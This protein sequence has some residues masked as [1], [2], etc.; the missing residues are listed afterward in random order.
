MRSSKRL[1]ILSQVQ[2]PSRTVLKELPSWIPDFSVASKPFLFGF[3]GQRHFSAAGPNIPQTEPFLIVD[4]A[5]S[6]EGFLVDTV[7]CAAET[8]GCYFVRTAAI[9]SQLPQFYHPRGSY[10]PSSPT[11]IEAY[12]KTLIADTMEDVY[13]A[14]FQFGFGFSAWIAEELL[15]A[16]YISTAMKT[17][18]RVSSAEQEADETKFNTLG[19]LEKGEHEQGKFH[20]PAD[21]CGGDNNTISPA[22]RGRV[23]L[24][25]DSE[26]L[27]SCAKEGPEVVEWPFSRRSRKFA[28]RFKD[29]KRG[30]RM[31]RTADNYLGLGPVSTEEGD[32]IWIL[33]GAPVPFVLRQVNEGRY[34]VI[35]EAYVHGIM[36]GEAVQEGSTSNSICLV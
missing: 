25:P 18:L 14:P 1:N 27:K 13:P 34:R 17:K 35:G 32:Q 8:R 16:S 22:P 5:L 6:M 15:S 11:R 7:L 12:W 36:H 31:F 33:S 24:L 26:F 4:E 9:V 29:V 10:S 2:D 23:R 20:V 3:P 21:D 19:A 30:H 28:R